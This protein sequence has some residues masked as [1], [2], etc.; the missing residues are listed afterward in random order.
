MAQQAKKTISGKTRTRMGE[1]GDN[2]KSLRAT[3]ARSPPASAPEHLREQQLPTVL[4]STKTMTPLFLPP[5]S[6]PH[7]Q[8]GTVTNAGRRVPSHGILSLPHAQTTFTDSTA[9]CLR[10][11]K[12]KM[13][14]V[15]FAETLLRAAPT[16]RR[17]DP[18][19]RLP[20]TLTRA[21]FAHC[22]RT[23]PFSAQIVSMP[24]PPQPLIQVP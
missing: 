23:L 21:L 17:H 11:T 13:S 14:G 4:M 16:R 5:L 10:T 6:P 12:K 2:D 8:H 1:F 18:E 3:W 22:T 19:V 7:G 9:T 20:P 15:A 24:Q